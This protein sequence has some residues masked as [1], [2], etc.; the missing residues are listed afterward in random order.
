MNLEATDYEKLT[1]EGRKICEEKE[2]GAG[3]CGSCS[4]TTHVAQMRDPFS[5][6]HSSKRRWAS[7]ANAAHLPQ[8]DALIE[9]LRAVIRE[10]RGY[11]ARAHEALERA[12]DLR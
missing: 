12:D 2:L 5:W 8:G 7:A 4:L 6:V 11:V 9:E 3:Y 1:H 10:A